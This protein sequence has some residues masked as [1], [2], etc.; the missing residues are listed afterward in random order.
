MLLDFKYFFKTIL[1]ISS[2]TNISRMFVIENM[3]LPSFSSKLL[4][5][6]KTVFVTIVHLVI[7]RYKKISKEKLNCGKIYPKWQLILKVFKLF[8]KM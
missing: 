2:S 6:H 5:L 1:T 8:T 3:R 4:I 7:N